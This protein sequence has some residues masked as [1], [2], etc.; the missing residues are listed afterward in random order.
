MKKINQLIWPICVYYI[1]QTMISVIGFT[2]LKSRSEIYSNY[3]FFGTEAEIIFAGLLQ[4]FIYLFS[5][6]SVLVF[7]KKEEFL[8]KGEKSEIILQ[9][10]KNAVIESGRWKKTA[11]FLLGGFLAVILNFIWKKIPFF[12]SDQIYQE[13]A[14]TQYSF[15]VWL[16]IFLYGMASPLAEEMMFRG[17]LYR[18]GRRHFGI[19]PA[20]LLSSFCFGLFH[21]NIVQASYGFLMAL[22]M[23]WLYEKEENFW[24]P[25]LFHSGANLAVYCLTGMLG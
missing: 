23:A 18:A 3:T 10:K 1:S 19:I 15:P 16:G 2:F 5:A 7:Y 24:I 22:C 14:K 11:V 8:Q 12:Q 6:L 20:I 25:F 17:I 9:D 13:V 21:G 4:I